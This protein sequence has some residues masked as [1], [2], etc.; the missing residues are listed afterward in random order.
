MDIFKN[1]SAVDMKTFIRKNILTILTD[2]AA[3]AFSWTGQHGN[4]E[5][6]Y[7]NFTK[8]LEGMFIYLNVCDL[9]GNA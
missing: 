4:L 3:C 2:E 8:I 9:Y 7:F 1:T 6:R 5:M